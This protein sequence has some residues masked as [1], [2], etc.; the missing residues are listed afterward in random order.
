MSESKPGTASRMASQSGLLM[1][2]NMFTLFV[3]F[4]FQI[5]L[6]RTLGAE[7]L[8]AFGLFEV[9]AQAAGT[10][11]GFGLATTLVRFIPQHLEL[12]E[13]QS[14]RAL[15]GSVYGFT[16]LGS[17]LA[18]VVMLASSSY[19]LQ[20]VPELQPNSPLLPFVCAM[21]V[22]G[23]LIGLSAQALRAF[24]DIRYMIMVASF[25]QLAVKVA[26]TVL[27]FW[28]GWQLS[29]YL[30]AVVVSVV[31]AL[32]GMLWGIHRHVRRLAPGGDDVT[33]ATRKAWWSFSRTMYF[34]S[35]L[36]IAAPP[37]ERLLLASAIDVA[38]VGVLMGIRQ[39]QSF[40]Q[41]LFQILVVVLAP[42]FVAAR[43]RSDMNE[44]KH[45]Y[46]IATDWIC[47]LGFPLLIFLLFFGEN[48]LVLYGKQ[49]AESGKWPLVIII[50]GQM[51]NLLT[52]PHG[53]MLN[54]LGHERDMFKLYLV[55]SAMLFTGLFILAPMFG[56][57]GVAIAGIFPVIFLNLIELYF[58]KKWLGIRWWSS[59]YKRLFAPMSITIFFA[60]VFKW[61][62]LSSDVFGLII[63]LTLLYFSFAFSYYLNG[64]TGEDNEIIE[65]IR[66]QISFNK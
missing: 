30:V 46:H 1:L 17:G 57:L 50:V 12:R 25:L 51:F 61:T 20:W 13:S 3:G 23:M 6:A 45:L 59:R 11:F 15:L 21:T 62:P 19:L 43:A 34:N 58:M 22:L 4:P 63:S 10:L 49:F 7:Q 60:L 29:G 56:L 64:L 36:G 14:V 32:I 54:M 26:A 39:L 16:L 55:S 47:R 37:A 27:L 41:V 24:L 8:G 2:G 9:I 31:V 5:Y 48:V 33:P 35:L 53:A 44:V 18:V 40:P 42:M 38:S 52:G 65:M 28:W 66:S